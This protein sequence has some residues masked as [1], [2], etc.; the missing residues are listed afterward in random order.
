MDLEYFLLHVLPFFLVL[1]A[2]KGWVGVINEDAKVRVGPTL[3]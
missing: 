2:L 1:V 3:F